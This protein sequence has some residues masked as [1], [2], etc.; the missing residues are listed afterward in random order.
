[1]LNG[2]WILSC[3]K[4]LGWETWKKI[5]RSLYLFSAFCFRTLHCTFSLEIEA[6]FFNVLWNTCQDL[7]SSF[8]QIVF[9]DWPQKCLSLFDS[10]TGRNWQKLTEVTELA[11]LCRTGRAVRTGRNWQKFTGSIDSN[12]VP[13]I[14]SFHLV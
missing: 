13:W 12:K 6:Y 10:K 5:R 1:M 14:L 3:R 11:E 7:V 4:K 9:L 8:W 2:V